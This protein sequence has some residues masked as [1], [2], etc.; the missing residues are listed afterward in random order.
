M[1]AAAFSFDLLCV[2]LADDAALDFLCIFQDVSV[3][4]IGSDSAF[5]SVGGSKRRIQ[6]AIIYLVTI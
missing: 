2:A 5:S 4:G 3:D 6:T 1:D